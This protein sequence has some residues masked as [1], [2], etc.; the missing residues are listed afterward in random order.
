MS[1]ESVPKAKPY[2]VEVTVEAPRETVWR[3]LTD[4]VEIRRWFGWDYE[5]LGEEI[6]Y[7]FIDHAVP[8]APDRIGFD[9]GDAFLELEAAPGAER[10]IVR[11]VNPGPLD[12]AE[13]A[14]LYDEMEEGWRAFF[15]QLK[16]YLERHPG[17]ERRSLFLAGD[18]APAELLP[19]L[20]ARAPGRQWHRS[21]HQ[22][23]T[24]LD[25]YGGGLA[26]VKCSRPLESA[27]SGRMNL[28]L[29]THGLD[30]AAFEGLKNDWS[31][32]WSERAGNVEVLP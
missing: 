1:E 13:W 31:A 30:D 3:T 24:A 27:E 17:E 16:H 15:Y 14:D 29:T 28:I 23:G 9:E 5:G 6:R 11:A 4:P 20:D 18:A 12:D 32:W 8:A 7:I 26:I 2:R 10:T 21:R 19:A 22:R 25:L